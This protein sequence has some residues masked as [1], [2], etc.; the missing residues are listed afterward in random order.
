MAT[1]TVGLEEALREFLRDE[2]IPALRG[3]EGHAQHQAVHRA[4][5]VH[6]GGVGQLLVE[7]HAWKINKSSYF[8]IL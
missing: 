3:F 8:S 5:V 6:V 4:E 7:F 2:D 1:L